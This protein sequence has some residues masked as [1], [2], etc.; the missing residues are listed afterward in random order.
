MAD[1][2]LGEKAAAVQGVVKGGTQVVKSGNDL[3][4]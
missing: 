2:A 1:G 4:H 3:L